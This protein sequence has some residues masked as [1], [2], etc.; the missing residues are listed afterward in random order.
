M[1]KSFRIH[2]NISNDTLLQVNM[3]QDFDFLEV[4]S[5][6]LR[7]NDAYRLHSSNYGVIIGRVLANDTFGIPNA[8]ISVF[9]PSDGNDSTEIEAIYPYKE[10]TSHDKDDR[11]YNLLPDY[12]DDDCYRVVG[13]FPNK[14]LMLD[15]DIQLE[16]YD[17][18]WKYTTITN[19]AGDYMLFGV[20]TGSTT[21][22]VDLDLSDIGVLSQKP[23]DFEYKGYNL[24]LF[25]SPSQ[26]K[27]STNLDNLTQIISQDKS[28]FVYPFWGDSENGIAAITR[29]DMQVQ[30][31][32]EP[33]CVFMG[34]IVSDNEGHAI[35]HRCAPDVEN[36]MNDQ[37]VGGSGTIEMIRR[38]TDGLIEEFP[39]QGNQLIDDNGVWCYQIPMN[40]DYVGTDEYGNIVPTDDPSKG[41]PTRAQVR[42]RISK[43]ETSD[44]GFSRHT[45]K[46]LVPMNP[47]FKE[48]SEVPQSQLTGQEAEKMYEFGSGTPLHC[49]RD[50]Y[51]NNVYSVKNY[52][53]KV[54][55]AHRPYSKNYGGL[56]GANLAED[57]NQIPFNKL[58]V[59]LPFVY[60]VLCIVFT[61]ITYVVMLINSILCVVFTIVNVINEILNTVGKL[62]TFGIVS[63]MDLLGGVLDLLKCIVLTA[64]IEEGNTAFYPGCW[65]CK[66]G[67]C[68]ECPE[69]MEDNCEKKYGYDPDELIDRIQRNLAREFK[70]IKL[71]FYQDWLN[72]CLYMPLW[73]WRKRKK[74]TFLFWTIS[75]AK[76]EFC[77]CENTYSR[78]KTYV[79]CDIPYSNNSL[80]L[81]ESFEKEQRWHKNKKA[82]VRYKRGLINPTTNRDDLV[83]YYY[84]AMQATIENKGTEDVPLVERNKNGFYAVRLYSTDIILL[85]NLNENNLYGIPQFFKCLPPTTSNIPPIA[86]IEEDIN[87]D[88][89]EDENQSEASDDSSKNSSVTVTTGMDWGNDDEAEDD[90]PM[91][92]KG[93]FMDL[94]C[95]YVATKG[96]S[97]VNVERL[98]ELGVNLDIEFMTSYA[99]SNETEIQTGSFQIDGFI[100]KIELDDLE[101]R[102][103]FA[104]LNH[105][106]FIPQP[107]QDS[108]SAYTTQVMDENTG[109][110]IPK[111]KYIY[112]V[113]F[114]GRQSQFMRRYTNGFQ[115]PMYDE[116]DESYLTFRLGAEN[117]AN[118]HDNSEERIRH[119]Y[120]VNKDSRPH[121]DTDRKNY[122]EYF[123]H[124]PLYNNSYYFYFGIKMGSTAIDKFNEMFYAPCV[125]EDK[126]PFSMEIDKRGKSYCPEAYDEIQRGRG[127]IKV[128]LDDIKKPYS[129]TL[130]DSYNEVI[131]HEDDVNEDYLVFG[132]DSQSINDDVDCTD[133]FIKYQKTGEY[134]LDGDGDKIEVTNQ[135]Y[136]IEVVDDDGRSI[137]EKVEL[138]KPKIAGQYVAKNLGTKFYNTATTRID[139]VCHEDNDFYGEINLTGITVDGYSARITNAAF[140]KYNSETLSY[141]VCITATSETMSSSNKITALVELSALFEE[142]DG[143]VR[144]CMCDQDNQVARQQSAADKMKITEA[145]LKGVML[146]IT[147]I[148]NDEG[149]EIGKQVKFFVYRPN[150]YVLK[151]TQYCQGG[152]PNG[153][154][155][156]ENSTS[157]IVNVANATPFN[158]Y[159]NSMPMRFILGSTNDN[160][161]AVIAST[162]RFYATSAITITSA[163]HKNISG[164]Y[165]LHQEN[166]YQF[167]CDTNTTLEKNQ[168]NW[169]DFVRINGSICSYASKRNILQYKFAT[170]FGISSG[171]Y[172]NNKEY[173]HI[174]FTRTG[175]RERGILRNISPMYKSREKVFDTYL[176]V[177]NGSLSVPTKYC[178]IVGYNNSGHTRCSAFTQS[179]APEFNKMWGNL[180][181]QYLGNYFAG[182]DNNASYINNA[183]IDGKEISIE[184]QPNFASISPYS[185]NVGGVYNKLKVMGNDEE[186][187]INQ[188]TFVHTKGNQQ[189]M[190][191]IDNRRSVNP[192]F[193]AMLVDRR[194]DYDFVILGPCNNFNFSLHKDEGENRAW[195]SLRISGYTYNGIEMSYDEEFNVISADTVETMKDSRCN[196]CGYRGRFRGACPKCGSNNVER[197]D[198]GDICVMTA[199]TRLEYSYNFDD[200]WE[201]SNEND[202]S[203]DVKTVFNC[204]DNEVWGKFHMINYNGNDYGY[205]GSID[206]DDK[207]HQLLKEFYSLNFANYDLRNFTWSQFNKDRLNTYVTSSITSQQGGKGK[208]KFKD[209]DLPFYVFGYPYSKQDNYNWYFEREKVISATT[210]PTK[211]FID[212]ANIPPM[213]DYDFNQESCSYEMKPTKS[214]N[215][216]IFSRTKAADSLSFRTSFLPIIEFIPPS[217]DNN[218]YGNVVYKRVSS[219][220]GYSVFKSSEINVNF[221]YNLKTSSQMERFDV[222][223]TSPRIIQVLPFIGGT[224]GTDGITYYKSSNQGGEGLWADGKTLEQAIEEV[225]VYEFS[226][227][228]ISRFFGIEQDTYMPFGIKF[229]GN[230][231]FK[232]KL[233]KEVNGRFFMKDDEFLKSDDSDFGNI[234]FKRSIDVN[235]LKVFT[236]L[237]EREYVYR[238]E[239]ALT[240]HIRTVEVSDLY[241]ARDVWLKVLS[242]SGNVK[243]SYVEKQKFSDV[244]VDHIEGEAEIVDT[245]GTQS[246]SISGTGSGTT[247]IYLQVLTFEMF[248]DT[249]AE[250][251]PSNLQNQAFSDY[252]M[253]G[254]TFLFTNNARQTYTIPC[255]EFDH[256]SGENNTKLRFTVRWTQDMGIL[257]DDK[258]STCK[259]TL[260]GKST[261]TGSGFIYKLDEFRLRHPSENKPSDYGYENATITETSIE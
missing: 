73:Y 187:T 198:T 251:E 143:M 245:G 237:C 181:K 42:F 18:Y 231:K 228:S 234:I 167:S 150:D 48:D 37:L 149:Q 36:G 139:Y 147:E 55:V 49:F 176:F 236:I 94:S 125:K 232:T 142:Y 195:K 69:E 6:K 123:Y 44:E 122:G 131:V 134:V 253:M 230:T 216:E 132:G 27:K 35:G 174:E 33:T 161:E 235:N 217:S 154:E 65:C 238:A 257:S 52:I 83:V 43:N 168:S 91:F 116:A 75:R 160:T 193:R 242:S 121:L 88:D 157:T 23:R 243:L 103:M 50:L 170:M 248:F 14:R 135:V 62:L 59:D 188:L 40:L 68:G 66:S 95:T 252:S 115:Q 212:I 145:N 158:T 87:N 17:K 206:I 64:G 213:I 84:A 99:N 119:F 254:Y 229:N 191:K 4:L 113:D 32:F 128:K 162:S 218:N 93:L 19:N 175:G 5:L 225:T 38:T 220:D 224:D 144:D 247:D 101:N 26:F 210:Y 239:D 120:L 169:E 148:L 117:S 24:N 47:I 111:F 71:D 255:N 70:I 118:Y 256:I 2:T 96:K 31:K 240:R 102:A 80:A 151:I 89:S 246:G 153:I 53:P 77:S 63:N 159:L 34:S 185:I 110:L 79:T 58:R 1:E 45:A 179:Y 129:Y 127:Y 21:L 152:C 112:P 215:G 261:G 67:G 108:I 209:I 3:Q 190:P 29:A 241:D 109:Y 244:N 20:P 156:S 197:T 192:W 41:I 199:N 85:G 227:S 155:V 189:L 214:D 104:T 106:G 90:T 140:I 208:E 56:K 92:R 177:D 105:I 203:E 100:N 114:D 60:I 57:R 223:T 15:D 141:E 28:V 78:L 173:A 11:R 25:D 130:Y 221:K 258:W 205:N 226:S 196:N 30:Y 61:I 249:N 165:G 222:Y 9:I 233:G 200:R 107:Y 76:N 10:V 133:Y 54:Q 146:G 124:M 22:H 82:S 138:D 81:S 98:S 86:L 166:T 16:I 201:Y 13:T 204:K 46:Y 74:K 202:C 8:R 260:L 194:F 172:A 178:N 259:V 126:K 7:Q 250:T 72:G 219:A 136:F 12:S 137:T 183:T 186:A 182:F 163:T 211:R 97:C 171:L 207:D 51:W 184:R 180:F 164:W 39:I